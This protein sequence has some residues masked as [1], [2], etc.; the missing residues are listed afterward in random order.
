MN[1]LR[2]SLRENCHRKLQ[3]PAFYNVKQVV[4]FV[5]FRA[6]REG[7]FVT[8]SRDRGALHKAPRD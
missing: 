2:R 3:G 6:D 5:G 7:P 1:T 4:A 8:E